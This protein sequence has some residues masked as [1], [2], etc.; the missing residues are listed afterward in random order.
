MASYLKNKFYFKIDLPVTV[1][2]DVP[3]KLLFQARDNNA[4]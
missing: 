2:N 3:I 4:Y 1:T